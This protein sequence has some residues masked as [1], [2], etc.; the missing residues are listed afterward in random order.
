MYNLTLTFNGETYKKRP[1]KDIKE[2]ILSTKPDVLHT[3]VYVTLKD[4]QDVRERKLSLKEGKKLF[5]SEDFINVFV[6]NLLLK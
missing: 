6:M 5:N 1:K 3:E 2:A 4:K